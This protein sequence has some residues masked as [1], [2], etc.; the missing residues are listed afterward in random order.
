MSGL[1]C[2]HCTGPN[3]DNICINRAS[4]VEAAVGIHITD[5]L[6]CALDKYVFPVQTRLPPAASQINNHSH[7]N[8][9]E[10]CICRKAQT[11]GEDVQL[12]TL[13]MKASF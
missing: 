11:D 12:D 2:G 8:E 10:T 6:T 5:A 7:D 1:H 4:L 13:Q 9:D 3:G